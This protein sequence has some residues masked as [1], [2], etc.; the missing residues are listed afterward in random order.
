[1]KALDK[2]DVLLA[3]VSAW[4]AG[5]LDDPTLRRRCIAAGCNR[6]VTRVAGVDLLGLA[7]LHL[8]TMTKGSDARVVQLSLEV[9]QLPG[10]ESLM[11]QAFKVMR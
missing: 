8:L 9:G 4:Q 3:A 1:M 10:L 5:Q 6:P 2:V 11:Q 7:V